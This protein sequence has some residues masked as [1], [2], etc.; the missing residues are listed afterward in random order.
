MPFVMLFF[1]CFLS[2][3]SKWSE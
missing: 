1:G 2:G 3:Y